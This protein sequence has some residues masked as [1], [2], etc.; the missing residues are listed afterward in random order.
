MEAFIQQCCVSVCRERMSGDS[1]PAALTGVSAAFSAISSW[2]K[3]LMRR[4]TGAV[5]GRSIDR[6]HTAL[7]S[8]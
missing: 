3:G 8:V 5:S 4:C 6:R 1:F 2:R 7:Q